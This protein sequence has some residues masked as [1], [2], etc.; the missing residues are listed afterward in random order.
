MYNPKR[1]PFVDHFTG[2]DLIVSHIER[3][4]CPTITSDQI[5]GGKPFRFS[6]DKRTEFD[7]MDLTK[8]SRPSSS[9]QPTR[10]TVAK[11][12]GD[13]IAK[14]ET[15]DKLWYRCSLLVEPRAKVDEAITIEVPK[16]SAK[17]AAWIDGQPI[18]FGRAI[19][20]RLFSCGDPLWLVMCVE[21]LEPDTNEL[22]L[23]TIT[24]GQRSPI[25]LQGTWE[26]CW[27]D[28]QRYDQPA[29]P[30]KFGASPSILISVD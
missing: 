29:L 15:G 16:T 20:G 12:P 30:A 6:Q 23:P 4:V 21:G 1:S 14:S 3:Y 13:R 5:L 2:N 28:D 24:I 27:D 9:G 8:V 19:D 17:T 26:Y 10:W 18:E 7:L 11:Q 22:L 25:R